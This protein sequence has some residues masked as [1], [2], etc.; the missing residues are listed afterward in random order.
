MSVRNRDYWPLFFANSQDLF[1]EYDTALRYCYLN[2]TGASLLGLQP[3]DAIGKTNRELLSLASNEPS[4]KKQET[5]EQQQRQQLVSQ[6]EPY[7]Q[8]VLSTG[9]M[10]QA[11]HQ[12]PTRQGMKYYEITYT[13]VPDKSG[14][15]SR[16]FSLGRDVTKREQEREQFADNIKR[17]SNLLWFNTA[18]SPLAMLGWDEKGRISQWSKRAEEIFGWTKEEVL[19][20]N[21]S[22]LRFVC[23]E[24]AESFKAAIPFRIASSTGTGTLPLHAELSEIEQ[25]SSIHRNYTKSGKLLWCQ[26]YNSAIACGAS[27]TIVSLV[28]D[29]TVRVRTEKELVEALQVQAQLKAIAQRSEILLQT[30]IAA[31]SDWIFAKDRSCRYILANKSFADAIGKT[32]GEILGKDDVELEISEEQIF[33]AADKTAYSDRG[34]EAVLSGR[35]VH[36]IHQRKT[37]ADGSIQIF[38]IHKIPLQDSEGNIFGILCLARQLNEPDRTLESAGDSEER[39]RSLV[40]HLAGSIY[41]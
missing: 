9:E 31:T 17:A 1:A 29:I 36:Q 11:V 28:E 8:R 34:D 19:G 6:I 14:K 16:I 20:K 39:V 12:I 26:W 4:E 41:R 2:P 18:N 27:V 23:E 30:A 35:A 13:P 22:D 37:P 33:G 10:R 15:V 40:T 25:N 38:D 5:F 7:L 32:V 3:T 24:D 21:Y